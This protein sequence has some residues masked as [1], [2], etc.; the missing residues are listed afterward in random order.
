V[1]KVMKMKLIPAVFLSDWREDYPEVEG[2][3]KL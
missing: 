2:L 1:L 3:E